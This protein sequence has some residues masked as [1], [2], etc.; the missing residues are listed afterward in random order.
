MF[1]VE[2]IFFGLAKCFIS[3]QIYID[4]AYEGRDVLAKVIAEAH[5]AKLHVEAWFEYGFWGDTNNIILL[6]VVRGK[7]S[8]FIPNL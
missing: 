5:R 7:Y 8:M 3:I 4:P 1:G 6:T 2:Y